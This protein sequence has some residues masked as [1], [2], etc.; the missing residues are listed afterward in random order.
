MT[1]LL[2]VDNFDSFTNNLAAQVYA[3]TGEPA[4]IVDNAIRYQDLP[5]DQVDGVI[6][7]PG[8]GRPSETADFGVCRE[9]IERCERPVLGVCLGHQGIADVFGGV[10]SHAPEPVHGVPHLVE[11]AAEGLFEGLPS[12][13]RVVRYHSLVVNR[14]PQELEVTARTADGLVM[15]LRHRRLPMWGVQFH[16]E[17]VETPLGGGIIDNFV[18]LVGQYRSESV[19]VETPAVQAFKEVGGLLQPWPD[20]EEVP[21]PLDLPMYFRRQFAGNPT[22]FWLDAEGSEHPDARYSVM[23]G[24]PDDVLM[25]YDVKRRALTLE[26]HGGTRTVAGD[27]FQ[28][29]G[30]VLDA[31]DVSEVQ[32][33]EGVPYRG[34]LVGYLGY[35]L[36]GLCGGEEA[37]RAETPDA[38]MLWPSRFVVFD[39]RD[40]KAWM[41]STQGAVEMQRPSLVEAPAPSRSGGFQ[42][43]AVSPDHLNL[44]DDRGTYLWKIREACRLIRDGESYEVCLTNRASVRAPD[45]R[46]RAYERMRRVSPVPYGAYLDM[47]GISV[48]SSSPECFLKVGRDR[49]VSTAPIKGTRP[50]GLTPDED[51]RMLQELSGSIK[52]RAENLMIVDLVRHDLNAVCSPGSVSV[53]RPFEVQSFR[54]VHQLVSVVEGQL[55]ADARTIDVIRS[56]FP[57]GSMTGAPKV[58]TMEIID[59][60]EAEAR[61]VYAGS[62]GWLD[63]SGAARLSVVIRTAVVAGDN[64]VFGV[65]GAITALSDPEEEFTETLVKASVPV[66]GLSAEDDTDLQYRAAP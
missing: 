56:C 59:R 39:H 55:R 48:L 13:L 18:R 62:I 26:G 28:L 29:V 15:A 6:I 47:G 64:A 51:V 54:A 57:P 61:G 2:I 20:V 43:G 30:D 37:H 12:P 3:S 5:L 33:P 40:R 8:P 58:R 25:T 52:D 63:A 32:L 17:S 16:P 45:D 65:G 10:V 7:S 41:V 23:G 19:T 24:A 50:R 38:M 36:K 9:L 14:V 22:A 35:E 21:W 1:R 53:P 46:L 27:L 44:R 42:P 34:G 11:H 4:V 66:H 60:L 49:R 31:V